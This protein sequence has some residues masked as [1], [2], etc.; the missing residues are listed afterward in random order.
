MMAAPF[1]QSAEKEGLGGWGGGEFVGGSRAVFLRRL[2]F[3]V[4]LLS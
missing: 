1:Q 3:L 2:G 4:V